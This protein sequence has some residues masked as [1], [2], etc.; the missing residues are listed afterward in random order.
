MHERRAREEAKRNTLER[1]KRAE[2]V[3]FPSSKAR[4]AG[5]YRV[6]KKMVLFEALDAGLSAWG[7][8]RSDVR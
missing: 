1:W 6:H 2:R 4:L 8:C 5:E 7:E 3:H